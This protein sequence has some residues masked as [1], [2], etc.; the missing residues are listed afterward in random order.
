[1]ATG[2]NVPGYVKEATE[3]RLFIT[4]L[5]LCNMAGA[6]M[7]NQPTTTIRKTGEGKNPRPSMTK[8]TIFPVIFPFQ[9]WS[10]IT[11]AGSNGQRFSPREY[12]SI[13][14]TVLHSKYR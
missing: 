10:A 8:D 1:M 4:F 14:F 9:P 2:S 6:R 13:H 3:T 7:A 11:R 12:T 5:I